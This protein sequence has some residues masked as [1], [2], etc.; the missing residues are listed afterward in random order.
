MN[1]DKHKNFGRI[2]LLTAALL[3]GVSFV[4][5]KNVLSNIPTFYIL[6]IRFCGAALILLPVCAGKIKKIDKSCIFISALL[7]AALVSAYV[8]QTYGLKL[9]TPAKNRKAAMVKTALKSIV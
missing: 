9:T 7:G 4:A 2:A 6:A 5:M 3:W 1:V 8:F